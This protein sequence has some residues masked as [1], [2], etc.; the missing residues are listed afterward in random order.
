MSKSGT[1]FRKGCQKV[2]HHPRHEKL[3]SK[4]VCQKVEHFSKRCVKK[5]RTFSKSVS[6]SDTP[7]LITGVLGDFAPN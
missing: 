2:T 5:W 4:K 1:L 7:I 6:K 3:S